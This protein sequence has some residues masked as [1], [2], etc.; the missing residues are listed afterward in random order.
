[1]KKEVWLRER[2]VHPSVPSPPR[3]VPPT[4]RRPCAS[5]GKR[6]SLPASTWSQVTVGSTTGNSDDYGNNLIVSYAGE[7]GR[8]HQV[9]GEEAFAFLPPLPTRRRF[10]RSNPKKGGGARRPTKR[11]VSWIAGGWG[12]VDAA[13]LRD[14]RPSLGA[15]ESGRADQEIRFPFPLPSVARCCCFR[16]PRS[17]GL[18]WIP[19]PL[20]DHRHE[21]KTVLTP[22]RSS[23]R[24]A[25]PGCPCWWP[26]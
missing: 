6:S 5:G 2:I 25:G 16:H 23:P 3:E 17:A 21:S 10:A 4:A 9:E 11:G 18:W 12:S 19:K 26:P 22:R 8:R 13:M 7:G 1:M 20:L 14:R 15:Q 24:T